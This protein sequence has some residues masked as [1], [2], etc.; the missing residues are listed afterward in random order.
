MGKS[1]GEQ[2]KE[3]AL[4]VLEMHPDGLKYTELR[5][6]INQQEGGKSFNSNT[7]N[8]NI[9]NLDA[10]LPDQVYKPSRG[11]FRLTKF[12]ET[13]SEEL[14]K[15]VQIEQKKV[16]E[17]DF[18][19]PFAN[20]LQNEIEDVTQAISLGGNRFK[21]KWGTPDVMGK[22]QSKKSDIIEGPIEIVSAEIKTDS[23][24]LITAFGQT[25]AY[26]LFSHKC[27]LVIPN[28]SQQDEIARIDS[29]CQIFGIG[30]VLFNP[31]NKEEPDF[32]IRNRPVKSEPDLFY[33]NKYLVKVEKELF[34]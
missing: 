4:K 20:W 22:K 32:E 24:Q 18:Y 29:L 14:I 19:E 11:L 12:K 3:M 13:D 28:N 9:W 23:N 17:E 7:I 16:K 10:V 5:K 8:G 26:K 34:S 31:E 6:S 27:Y 1:K 15:D 2:I 33:T 25:C 21:D 30:L